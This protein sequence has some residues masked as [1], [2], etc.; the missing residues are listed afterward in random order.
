VVLRSGAF[1]F[2]FGRKAGDDEVDVRCGVDE[3]AVGGG[4]GGGPFDAI[5]V[6]VCV[7]L[8]SAAAEEGMGDG[9]GDVVWLALLLAERDVGDAGRR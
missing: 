8:R 3:A 9:G 5:K 6:I 2:G 1:G 4:S 7:R